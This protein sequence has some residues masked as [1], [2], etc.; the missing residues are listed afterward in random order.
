MVW[1]PRW[2]GKKVG[3]HW[4][5]RLAQYDQA[6]AQQGDGPG[7]QQLR[8]QLFSEEEQPRIEAALALRKLQAAAPR[9]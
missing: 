8:Q 3:Q 2:C 6:R 7:L 1:L 9:S 5:Q 4:Q